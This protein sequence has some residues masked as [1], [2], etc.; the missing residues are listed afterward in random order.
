MENADRKYD[1]EERLMG[2]AG[3][4]IVVL[5]RGRRVPQH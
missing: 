2:F 3:M 5:A 4:V 1:L